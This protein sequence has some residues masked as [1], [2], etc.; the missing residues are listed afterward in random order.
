MKK[1]AFL[2][3][4]AVISLCVLLLVFS[5]SHY[6]MMD[7]V[8]ESAYTRASADRLY[9]VSYNLLFDLNSYLSREIAEAA[10]RICERGGSPQ[11]L[12]Y[13]VE[14]SRWFG[15]TGTW[16]DE[17][18]FS[19]SIS[20]Q[21]LR[22]SCHKRGQSR[23]LVQL[24]Q[25]QLPSE[26]RYYEGSI[27]IDALLFV[28]LRD[29][30]TGILRRTQFRVRSLCPIR[31]FLLH[32]LSH[33]FITRVTERLETWTNGKD[34]GDLAENISRGIVNTARDFLLEIHPQFFRGRVEY[35][36]WTNRIEKSLFEV[37]ILLGLV[38]ITDMGEFSFSLS[39]SQLR[40]VSYRLQDIRIGFRCRLGPPAEGSDTGECAGVVS[41]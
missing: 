19:S 4:S 5:L 27:N 14:L 6:A 38:E 21:D 25:L 24:S 15:L 41:S 37:S 7:L 1:N 40:R 22:F 39:S 12:K 3:S 8:D 13:Y 36:V 2:W 26:Y 35:H 20:I 11:D 32:D 34:A 18:E 10:N 29:T 17:E 30:Q 31:I 9:I 33:S 23:D 28:S 16:L